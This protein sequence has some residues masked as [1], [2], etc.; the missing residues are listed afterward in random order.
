MKNLFSV[1]AAI[2]FSLTAFSQTFP[3]INP[4]DVTIVRDSFGVPHIFG[5]TDADCAY[6][7]AWAN[8][9][10]AFHESQ[11]LIYASKGFM[12]RKGGIEGV[13]ADYFIHAI[14]VRKLVEERYDKDLSPEFK[15]YINGF[16]QGIN[17]YA[18]AHPDEV[19]IKKAF[20][21]TEKDVVSSFVAVM[22]MLV[23]SQN[24][25][26]GIV[27]GKYDKDSIDFRNNQPPVG[28]NAYAAKKA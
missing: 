21:I 4:D 23:G 24:S 19:K 16:V 9:E 1:V 11:D 12:G 25:V 18:K 28:S 2:C 15:K 27:S 5:K 14:G 10:D 26:G 22:S 7:L 8:A 6:G 3:P 20:P 17:A 13:K